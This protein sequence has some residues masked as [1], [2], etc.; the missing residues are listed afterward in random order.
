VFDLLVVLEG[1]L[2]LAH[3]GD[4]LVVAAQ[5]VQRVGARHPRRLAVVLSGGGDRA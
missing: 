2:Q 1:L 5:R 3:V 4:D